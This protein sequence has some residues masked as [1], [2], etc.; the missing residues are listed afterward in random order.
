MGSRGEP[1]AAAPTA[2]PSEPSGQR[3]HGYLGAH[4]NS[5]ASR[6]DWHVVYLFQGF[7]QLLSFQLTR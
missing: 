2:C 7:G 3:E 4:L 6:W 1:Q 5:Q